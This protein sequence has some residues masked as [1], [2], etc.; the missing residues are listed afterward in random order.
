MSDI[1]ELGIPLEAVE[2]IVARYAL[3]M[4]VYAD[5]LCTLCGNRGVMDTRRVRTPAGVEV[6]RLNYCLCP[7]GMALRQRGVDLDRWLTTPPGGQP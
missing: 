4:Y 5:G 7:N 2:M 1:Y 3:T 6:G